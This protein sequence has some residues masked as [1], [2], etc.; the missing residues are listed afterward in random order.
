MQF[1]TLS[2]SSSFLLSVY[3]LLHSSSLGAIGSVQVVR[4][5]TVDK[6]GNGNFTTIQAAINSIPDGN[7]QW[8]RVDIHQGVYVYIFLH[9]V[10][11]II[12]NTAFSLVC[13]FILIKLFVENK[14]LFQRK[15]SSF[16]LRDRIGAQQ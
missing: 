13:C 1:H 12:Q 11:S 10:K 14:L 6:S 7:S 3:L 2:F 5:I 15:S 8:I 4:T 16:C 9:S